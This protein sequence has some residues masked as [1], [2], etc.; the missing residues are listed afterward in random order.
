MSGHRAVFL[1]RDGVINENVYYERWGEFEGPLRPE[2]VV[3]L[4]GVFDAMRRFSDAGFLLFIVSNQGA[5]AKG[6]VSLK[7]LAETARHV[8]SLIAGAGLK[9]AEAYYSFSHPKGVAPFFSGESLERKP[10][11]YFL[12]LAE[13]FYDLDLASS[14]MIGDRATDVMCGRAAG[15]RT[16]RIVN[17]SNEI[18]PSDPAPD[19]IADSLREAADGILVKG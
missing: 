15:C 5:F 3:I 4:P 2:D 6:K 19:I 16:A 7:S 10:N 14:W 17:D 8:D 12:K 1:D 13:A 18:S 11:P 9:V